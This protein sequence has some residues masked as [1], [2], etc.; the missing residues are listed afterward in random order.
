M[1]AVATNQKEFE[2]LMNAFDNY[3]KKA[4][5]QKSY[6][7]KRLDA[8]FEPLEQSSEILQKNIESIKLT[9]FSKSLKGYTKDFKN[10]FKLLEKELRGG[11]NH[12]TKNLFPK[13]NNV[14]AQQ[15]NNSGKKK[16]KQPLDLIIGRLNAINSNLV[17]IKD[18][19]SKDDS[20]GAISGKNVGKQPSTNQV[21]NSVIKKEEE[22][23]KKINS[24]DDD[25]TNALIGGGGVM[26]DGKGGGILSMLGGLGKLTL[27][28]GGTLIGIPFLIRGIE[29]AIDAF[30]KF[31]NAAGKGKFIANIFFRISNV[32]RSLPKFFSFIKTFFS[33]GEEA[34]KLG[35]LLKPSLLGNLKNFGKYIFKGGFLK[36]IGRIPF[37][38][39]VLSAAYAYKR[40]QKGDWVGGT[41]DTISAIANLFPGVGS[42]VSLLVDGVSMIRDAALGGSDEA[43][44]LTIP[45]QGKKMWDYVKEKLWP[46]VK[47]FFSEKIWNPIEK[48][49]TDW[50]KDS[51]LGKTIAEKISTIST[52]FNSFKTELAERFGKFK[53]TMGN[54]W[55]N[56]KDFFGGIGA[57]TSELG[58]AISE[59]WQDSFLRKSL[60]W[61]WEHLK[62]FF[63]AVGDM[64]GWIKDKVIMP[65]LTLIKPLT[66]KMGEW[67]NKF[68]NWGEELAGNLWEKLKEIMGSF[69][70][71]AL[72]GVGNFFKNRVNVF[73]E[74]LDNIKNTGKMT[75]EAK[76][77]EE[78]QI[79]RAK[80]MD[81]E[82]EAARKIKSKTQEENAKNK[83]DLDEGRPNVS[84]ID[85]NKPNERMSQQLEELN[86]NVKSLR[87]ATL[88]SGLATAEVTARVGAA[89]IGAN[90]QPKSVTQIFGGSPDI[91]RIR[92]SGNRMI[93]MPIG[94]G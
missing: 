8:I 16:Q 13:L 22:K 61:T 85:L 65:F 60:D 25:Q 28:A 4:T 86:S 64:F 30:Q 88:A 18:N 82:R 37:L 73:T 26:G 24:K 43:K 42:A 75:R 33:G 45:Q 44:K 48:Y 2:Q 49:A 56:I 62:M 5:G 83:K 67:S 80:D 81:A 78:R 9:D 19:F 23:I 79:Q 94:I 34:V 1:A 50:L 74:T 68:L 53:E 14:T 32:V 54:T 51:P 47:K 76:E 46:N 84:K 20:Y 52:K 87:D 41:L 91:D 6:L 66:D 63:G 71:K 93:N 70:D 12:L 10:L 59:W 69:K 27:F 3:V 31:D 40:F 55:Q 29:T 58:K 72:E 15:S 38:G 11:I 35:G 57:M 39:T 90:N 7:K 36:V 77:F 89:T 17:K 92:M 21:E